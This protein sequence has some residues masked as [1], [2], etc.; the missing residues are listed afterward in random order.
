MSEQDNGSPEQVELLSKI[1]ELI[2]C[3]RWALETFVPEVGDE[4]TATYG[5]NACFIHEVCWNQIRN[6]DAICQEMGLPLAL[7][8]EPV[9]DV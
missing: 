5:E 3:L 6:Y 8:P 4:L 2:G 9:E 1:H 7:P